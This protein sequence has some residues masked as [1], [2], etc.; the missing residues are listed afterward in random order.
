MD[1]QE[2][3]F[4]YGLKSTNSD[5]PTSVT[6]VNL[7]RKPAEM[8][9]LDYSGEPVSYG[10][11]Q[12]GEESGMTTYITHPWVFR[13]YLNGAKLLGN[14]QEVYMPTATEYDEDGSPND[15]NV[16]ITMP[17]YS[18]QESCLM[19]IRQLVKDKDYKSLNIPASLK[20]ELSQPPD[21]IKEL[22]LLNSSD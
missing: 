20:K 22:R 1:N 5:Q 10:A 8:W 6:F 15:K 3:T 9:W 21:L 12:P 7:T 11:I 14:R 13:T 16:L 2:V 19:L 4:N 18:L 17:V